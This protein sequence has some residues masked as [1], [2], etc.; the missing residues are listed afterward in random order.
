VRCAKFGVQ[1]IQDPEKPK[2]RACK[3]CA[4]L[5]EKCERLEVENGDARSGVDKGKSKAI[6]TSP[7]GGKKRKKV[8]KSAAV[9][10]DNEIQEVAGPL[11]SG[12]RGSGNQVFLD[13]MDQLVELMGE[14]TGEV[15]RMRQAQRSIA[16]SNDQVGRTLE[17]FLEECHWFNGLH[18]EP[19]TDPESDEEVD[20]EEIDREVEGLKQEMEGASD[21]LLSHHAPP[22]A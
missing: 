18:N 1:C 6:A 7:R 15:R 16:R 3:R 12:S 21:E 8:K 20:P 5:K 4:G 10:V 2:Q 11:K 19:G 14:L 9:V 22:R 13:R 17:M